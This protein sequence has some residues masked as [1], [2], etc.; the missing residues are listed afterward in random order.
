M[1]AVVVMF[2]C[3]SRQQKKKKRRKE[4]YDNNNNLNAS[5]NP[6]ARYFVPFV[7]HFFFPVDIYFHCS[8]NVLRIFLEN[9]QHSFGRHNITCC[10]LLH[11][12]SQKL[13]LFN[14]TE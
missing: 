4:E 1:C 7:L 6:A 5:A 12:T 14:T 3:F 8:E 11:F 13:H 2:V 9:I 10:D